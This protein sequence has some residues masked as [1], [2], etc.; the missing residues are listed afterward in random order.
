MYFKCYVSLHPWGNLH[1]TVA[2]MLDDDIIV[3]KFQLQSCYCI[4]QYPW[5]RCTPPIP[6]SY[7]LIELQLFLYKDDSSIK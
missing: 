1:G 2:N 3:S 7:E 6:P 4:D 5:E